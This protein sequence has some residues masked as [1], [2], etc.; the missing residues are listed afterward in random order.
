MRESSPYTGDHY[1]PGDHYVVCDEC[2]LVYRRSEVRKRWDNMWV[3]AKDWEERHPQESVRGKAD[4]IRVDVARPEINV[5][6]TT[7]ITQDDL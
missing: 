7:P 1:K 6:I 4:H 5:E 2:G 3:C